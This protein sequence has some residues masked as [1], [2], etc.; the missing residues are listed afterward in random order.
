MIN[1]PVAILHEGGYSLVV[2]NGDTVRTFTGRGV[3][4]LYG[5]LQEEQSCLKGAYVA[6][7][8]VGKGAAALMIIGGVKKLHAD[9]VS[10][11]AL[12]LLSGS[13][14]EVHY[15]QCVSKI[16]NRTHTDRCPVEKLCDG[17][18]DAE[19][20]LPLIRDFMNRS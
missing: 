13:D 12:T 14:M 10:K 1:D 16:W 5:L 7:K 20:C 19:A 4:D 15:E 11:P 3:S 6:D 8:V 2:S 18:S 17:I 9:V